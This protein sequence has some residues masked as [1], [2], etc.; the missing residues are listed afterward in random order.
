MDCPLY[1]V[2]K[3]LIFHLSAFGRGLLGLALTFLVEVKM[4]MMYGYLLLVSKLILKFL[5]SLHDHM[6]PLFVDFS[7]QQD[8]FRFLRSLALLTRFG[9]Q[10]FSVMIIGLFVLIFPHACEKVV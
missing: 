5:F 1:L 10:S 3:L 2:R 7:D 8:G 9:L 6:L 4:A